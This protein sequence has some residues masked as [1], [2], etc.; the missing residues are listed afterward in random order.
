MRTSLERFALVLVVAIPVAGFIAF[1]LNQ[2][3]FFNSPSGATAPTVAQ[4]APAQPQSPAIL[5]LDNPQELPTSVTVG[6]LVPFSFTIKDSG[7][8][9]STYSYKVSVMWNDGTQD[10][11]DENSVPLAGRASTDISESLKF[12]TAPA[13][14]EV[15]IEILNPEQTIQFALPRA[16]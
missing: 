7:D 8:T 11:I 10:V 12:E 3:G 15:Y 5:T 9:A 6:E 1:V 4:T 16:K 2:N 13:T 14:A